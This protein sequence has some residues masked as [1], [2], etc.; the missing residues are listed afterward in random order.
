M[1]ADFRCQLDWI[2]KYL[3][4]WLCLFWNGCEGVFHRRL[5]GELE[6]TKWGRFAL[7]CG[8][9]PPNWTEIEQ[10][11][12]KGELISF[13]ELGYIHSFSVQEH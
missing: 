2:K 12:R 8:P 7:Y 11:Q 5:A 3:D 10:K 1:V 13:L 9:A 4:N 6:W